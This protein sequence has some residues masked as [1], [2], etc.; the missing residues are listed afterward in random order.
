MERLIREIRTGSKPNGTSVALRPIY[1]LGRGQ[2]LVAGSVN[3]M[4]DFGQETA[5]M[6]MA[7]CSF[8]N[9]PGSPGVEAVFPFC[10]DQGS[11]GDLDDS[12]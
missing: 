2:T 5:P 10:K 4:V 12:E 3:A 1:H 7:A 8:R 11:R 9:L 6:P